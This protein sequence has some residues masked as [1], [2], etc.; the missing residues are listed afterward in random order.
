M[1]T[2]EFKKQLED[3]GY[4]HIVE[5]PNKGICALFNF[6][7]TTGLVIGIDEYSYQGRYCYSHPV[8]A[9]KAL[10]KWDGVGDPPGDWIKYKGIGGERCNQ[11]VEYDF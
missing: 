5:F 7:Y 11:K 1:L 4:H 3:M 2:A 6:I 8:H 9:I 10:K